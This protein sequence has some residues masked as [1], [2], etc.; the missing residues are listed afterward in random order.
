MPAKILFF[1]PVLFVLILATVI[2]LS[3]LF[4]KCAFRR[5]KASSEERKAYACG[6]DFNGHLIQPDYGQFFPFAFFFTILH[7][8]VLMIATIPKETPQS[9]LI[10][11][12]YV[13]G[14]A[15]SMSILLRK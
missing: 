10:A 5:T 9:F 1:P 7:V 4:S 6:E 8:V 14:A 11:L 3:Y 15:I 12:L 2:F 13:I